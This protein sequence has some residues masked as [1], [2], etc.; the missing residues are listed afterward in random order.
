MSFYGNN[1]YYSIDSFAK[2]IL[3]SL[4]KNR[5]NVDSFPENFDP[6]EKKADNTWPHIEAENRES[7]FEISSGNQWIQLGISN[8]PNGEGSSKNKSKF[9][10]MH[11]PAVAMEE[12][13]PCIIPLEVKNNLSNAEKETL[14]DIP[15]LEFD[16]YFSIP[17]IEYDNAGHIVCNPESDNNLYTYIKMPSNPKDELDADLDAI[18]NETDGQIVTTVNAAKTALQSEINGSNSRI[19]ALESSV[20]GLSDRYNQFSD[21]INILNSNVDK[22]NTL[23]QW[24]SAITGNSNQLHSIARWLIDNISGTGTLNPKDILEYKQN[25]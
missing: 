9:C 6:V 11:G 19:A 8:E 12:N 1:Y 20:A 13:Q 25:N 2:I 22:L 5:L 16:G 14:K 17:I 24:S 21:N 18:T 23:A 3:A 7:G 10:I 15:Q 4:G